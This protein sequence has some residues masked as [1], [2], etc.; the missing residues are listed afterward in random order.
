VLLQPCFDR[1]PRRLLLGFLETEGQTQ[2]ELQR[3]LG[4][5]AF[6][7]LRQSAKMFGRVPMNTPPMQGYF[8]V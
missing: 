3:A 4:E 1:A 6:D 8:N 2:K 5:K 7:R